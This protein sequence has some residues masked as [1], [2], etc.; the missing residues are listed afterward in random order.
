AEEIEARMSW[1]LDGGRHGVPPNARGTGRRMRDIAC[2]S[3][4]RRRAKTDS[5]MLPNRACG[6]ST[7]QC[8]RARWL[9]ADRAV[10]GGEAGQRALSLG[11]AG[12]DADDV[13]GTGGGEPLCVGAAAHQ[14]ELAGRVPHE[15]VIR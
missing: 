13:L 5:R 2:L 6:F 15:L 9:A 4:R 8:P 12:E 10:A 1:L 11:L 14:H 7:A 3:A